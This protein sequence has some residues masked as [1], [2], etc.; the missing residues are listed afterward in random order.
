MKTY[1]IVYFGTLLLTMFILPIISRLAKWYCL[2]D[3]P[4]PRKV[5][6]VPIPRVGGIAF[7]I[8]T[9]TFLLIEFFLSDGIGQ[10]F[11]QSRSEFIALLT[12]AGF[13]FAV[14]LFDDLHSV[15]GYIKL[16]CLIAV[17][18]AICAS[19]A[20]ISSISLGTSFGFETGLAAW[21][22]TILWIVMIT[23][24]IS[25]IDGLDGL[26]A[27]I[28]V[29]V[30]G[31][32]TLIA[33][34][35]GQ[36]AMA[37][38][39]LALLGSVTGFLMFNFYPAKIF[40]GDCGSMFLGFMIGAGS[41]IC[42]MKT[43]TLVGLAIPFLVLIV[44][45]LDMGFVVICR[46]IL[47]RCSIFTPDRSHFHHHLLDLGLPQIV[48][49]IMIYSVTIICAS[50]GMLILTAQDGW[51]LVLLAGGLLLMLV[52]FACLQ[53][54]R[55][56]KILKAL[57]RNRAV[58]REMGEE[59]QIF[60][61]TRVK[62]RESRSFSAWWDTLSTMGREMRFQNI[63]FWHRR[64]GRYVNTC[65]W[66]AP[67]GQSISYG[68]INLSLRPNGNGT[69]EYEIKACIPADACLE[70]GGRQAML[71]SR[72]ID[73]FPAPEQKR[74]IETDHRPVNTMPQSITTE[75]NTENGK[76]GTRNILAIYL[77]K[78]GDKYVKRI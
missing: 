59:K 43:S 4:G 55:F 72:L 5:H 40:M 34:W 66:S 19:G 63:E 13:M 11:R 18:L 2:V 12:G 25:V 33:L 44:P 37:V 50:I 6:K 26:A 1:V 48:V 28:A 15:R 16:I 51:R 52:I 32:I 70:A 38:V 45:I 21:P 54:T 14:G 56:R 49:V 9:I 30:C 53:C 3:I 67:E 60:E 8:S 27:G 62:M 17:S 77:Q 69:A 75:K 23:V 64:N 57:K 36:A 47:N 61:T 31:T 73:E 10:S 68:T 35:S 58:A 76:S 20:T 29:I 71:L 24:C 78:I 7:V 41:I 74:E 39:M 65:S 42:Q 22:L 46:R